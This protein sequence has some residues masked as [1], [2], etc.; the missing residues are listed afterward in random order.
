VNLT[1]TQPPRDVGDF[2]SPF[3][4]VAF[5]SLG[6]EL[7][8]VQEFA[9][10]EEFQTTSLAGTATTSDTSNPTQ[11]K[12][13]ST[14]LPNYA[15]SLSI[16]ALIGAPL[17]FTLTLTPPYD[18]AVQIV[19]NKLVGYGTLVKVQWGYTSNSSNNNLLSDIYVFRNEHPAVEYGQDITITLSGLDLVAGA[20][21]RNTSKVVYNRLLFPTD[22]HILLALFAKTKLQLD[23]TNVPPT[24]TLFLPQLFPPTLEQHSTD[25]QFIRQILSDNNL[26][27]HAQGAVFKVYS[28]SQLGSEQIAYR[29]LF[30]LQP[31]DKRDIPM[32]SFNGNPRPWI[33]NPPEAR[34]LRAIS[35][36]PDSGATTAEDMTAAGLA[37]QQ[38]VGDSNSNSDGDPT[39]QA[40]SL[41]SDEADDGETD[42]DDEIGAPLTTR[43]APGPDD[44]GTVHSRPSQM[45]NG[46]ERARQIVR[47]AAVFG[48]V[49]ATLTAPGMPDVLPPMLVGVEGVGR[50]FKGP[51]FVKSVKHEISTSGYEMEVELQ[52]H[53]EL[54]A[55][56]TKPT[57]ETVDPRPGRGT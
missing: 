21:M 24:S 1:G 32:M 38:N 17:K 53:M 44:V 31:E 57:G 22:Y 47:G 40:T 20:G 25:W 6:K 18:D 36:D 30:R 9:G 35:S 41:A 56:G 14:Q 27:G 8:V 29:F 34:G 2:F 16:E 7:G 45:S 54:G 11:L 26:A 50:L 43:P 5:R 28:P 10:Q 13:L 23:I 12:F 55:P 33:F 4:R 48:N 3:F 51:Y 19:D 46:D 52:R 49:G 37:D 39:D 15:A 42:D